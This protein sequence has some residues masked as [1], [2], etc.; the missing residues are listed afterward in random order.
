MD[1]TK[2]VL[3]DFTD[4]YEKEM[5]AIRKYMSESF[6]KKDRYITLF[7]I[8]LICDTLAAQIGENQYVPSEEIVDRL[9]HM[10]WRHY[11]FSSKACSGKMLDNT[12]MVT[13]AEA[14]HRTRLLERQANYLERA[15]RVIIDRLED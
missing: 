12:L 3:N 6:S 10:N 5:E 8:C 1:V 14:K 4:R 9:K 2:Q 7:Y 13:K 11:S 15:G